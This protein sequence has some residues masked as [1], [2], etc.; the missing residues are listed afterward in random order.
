MFNFLHRVRLEVAKNSP[1]LPSKVKTQIIK[2]FVSTEL[3]CLL[4]KGNLYLV[5]ILVSNLWWLKKNNI[6]CKILTQLWALRL[7]PYWRQVRQHTSLVMILPKQ[8]GFNECS[9]YLCKEAVFGWCKLVNSKTRFVKVRVGHVIKKDCKRPPIIPHL[10]E[11]Q[12]GAERVRN[13]IAYIR[14]NRYF[15]AFQF[16]DFWCFRNMCWSFLCI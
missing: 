15:V 12:L 8:I 3:A 2:S 4:I 5:M 9:G 14:D 16:G 6:L 13:M 1:F 10:R 7:S 11:T